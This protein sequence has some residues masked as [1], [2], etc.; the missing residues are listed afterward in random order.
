MND[1]PK[2]TPALTPEEWTWPNT[3]L[4]D[5]PKA[6][7]FGRAEVR[8]VDA[9]R[10]NVD[11][12]DLTVLA[13]IPPRTLDDRGIVCDAEQRHG[14]AALALHGQSFGFTREDVAALGAALNAREIF[15]YVTDDEANTLRS[16]AARI[17]SLLPPEAP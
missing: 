5:N 10:D 14:L 11:P 7:I 17:T 8:E 6:G 13:I 2:V 15:P 16:L 12:S 4:G 1:A 3:T 9:E